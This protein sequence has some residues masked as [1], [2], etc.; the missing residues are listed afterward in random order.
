MLELSR[1]AKL[2]RQ[3]LFGILNSLLHPMLVEM[4]ACAGYDF[5]ILDME[6]RAHDETRLQHGIQ[7]AQN[8]G[9]APLVRVPDATAKRIGRVLTLRAHGI[10]LPQVASIAQMR[11]PSAGRPPQQRDP[12]QRLASAN[13]MAATD[14]SWVSHSSRPRHLLL[15]VHPLIWPVLNASPPSNHGGTHHFR[16]PLAQGHDHP[17]QVVRRETPAQIRDQH[18][19]LVGQLCTPKDVLARRQP[20]A[21]LAPGDWLLFP[22]ARA[23]AWNIAHRHVLMHAAPRTVWLA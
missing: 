17:F 1:S 11:A 10:V 20:I 8:Q 9:C 2:A 12:L 22:L 7:L 14:I 21:A 16:P 23:Y 19:T 5:V 18:V 15:P 13:R 6:H 3:P 4:I